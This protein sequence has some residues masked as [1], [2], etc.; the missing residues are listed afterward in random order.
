[1][2]P[3]SKSFYLGSI[4]GGFV[5][6]FVLLGIGIAIMFAGV[7][8]AG[9]SRE[10]N[11]A[12]ALGSTGLICVGYIPLLFAAVMFYVLLYKAWASI[13]GGP[14]P[15]RTTPGKA[16]G[17]MFIPLFNIYWMFMAI[18]GWTQ[19]YNAVV[20]QKNPSAPRMP[21]KLALVWCIS[22]VVGCV[23]LS[24]IALFMVLSKMCDGINALAADQS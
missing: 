23:P 5:L 17:F 10:P 2:K 1:M 22:N 6:S 19:D 18:W 3:V 21:E 15:V 11:A 12:A 14:V 9:N 20:A 7:I 24:L 13:Q 4:V 16:V 8:A